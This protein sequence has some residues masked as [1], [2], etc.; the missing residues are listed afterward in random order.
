MNEGQ[1]ILT[2]DK[3]QSL[4]ISR[5]PRPWVAPS[6]GQRE[7]PVTKLSWTDESK[8]KQKR[9]WLKPSEICHSKAP[10]KPPADGTGF[11][12]DGQRLKSG[13]TIGLPARTRARPR[14]MMS[15]LFASALLGLTVNKL[16]AQLPFPIPPQYFETLS[17]SNLIRQYPDRSDL[18]NN[19]AEIKKYLSSDTA[20]S[21]R[22]STST[23]NAVSRQTVAYQTKKFGATYVSHLHS[24]INFSSSQFLVEEL[25]CS[26]NS[27]PLNV[28]QPVNNEDK[29]RSDG[30]FDGKYFV[31]MPGG[32]LSEMEFDNLEA[33]KKACIAAMQNLQ[34][35]STHNAV[36]ERACIDFR[37]FARFHNLGHEG[38]IPN[39]FVFDNNHF[40]CL[41]VRGDHLSGSISTNAA[42]LVDKISYA[43]SEHYGSRIFFLFYE[44]RF[45]NCPWYPSRIVD[46][47]QQ[48]SDSYS[49]QA[50]HTVHNVYAE[51]GEVLSI[52]NT[53]AELYGANINRRFEFSNDM[54]YEA[55]GT[56]LVARP[57]LVQRRSEVSSAT[58]NTIGGLFMGSSVVS[59]LVVIY[60]FRN[61]KRNGLQ[62]IWRAP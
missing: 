36:L 54:A 15:Y 17:E 7:R 20:Y 35:P 33:F 27:Y 3:N 49:V 42:G 22:L 47:R 40:A 38:V 23:E 25:N 37:E 39:S 26:P 6:P 28:W 29:I 57:T 51:E 16:H 2:V 59:L 32:K 30:F 45:T 4:D 43:S 13:K 60:F 8:R 48:A 34:P 14:F 12:K 18:S 56:Q 44:T 9:W 52:P 19:V 5:H 62:I 46:A 21:M 55:V 1:Y 61:K 24:H 53:T 11:E 10:F 41:G 50:V 58:R 31:M